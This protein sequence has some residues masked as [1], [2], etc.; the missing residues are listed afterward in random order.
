QR[1]IGFVLLKKREGHSS[2]WPVESI[3]STPSGTSKVKKESST[4]TLVSTSEKLRLVFWPRLSSKCIC[5][6]VS[7]LKLR[8]RFSNRLPGSV[9]SRRKVWRPPPNSSRVISKDSARVFSS[10]LSNSAG[11]RPTSSENG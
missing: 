9:G 4:S 10:P 5:S 7:P 8:V 1:L 3:T 6:S 2:P 11:V